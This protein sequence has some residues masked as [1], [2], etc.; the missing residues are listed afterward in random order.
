M[1]DQRKN[2]AL[3]SRL[4]TACKAK[5]RNIEEFASS[6]LPEVSL[7]GKVQIINP[8]KHKDED[9]QASMGDTFKKVIDSIF[10]GDGNLID[11]TGIIF[12]QLILPSTNIIFNGRG[13]SNSD[14]KEAIT[15]A[16][17]FLTSQVVYMSNQIQLLGKLKI[18]MS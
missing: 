17:E 4:F 18:L 10:S 13:P 2:Y 15:F 12:Q 3:L 14:G 11:I 9:I 1:T 16:T 6:A 7:N 5:C 8:P